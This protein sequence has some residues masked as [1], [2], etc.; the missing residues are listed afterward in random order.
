MRSQINIKHEYTQNKVSARTKI[1]N[2][3]AMLLVAYEHNTNTKQGT[4]QYHLKA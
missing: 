4:R 3:I 2:P 1:N